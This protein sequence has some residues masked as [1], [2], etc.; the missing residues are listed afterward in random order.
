MGFRKQKTSRPALGA[1]VT[2]CMI[3]LLKNQADRSGYPAPASC[4]QRYSIRKGLC[5][6][7]RW[8][9]FAP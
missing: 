5:C 2:I 9:F 7:M 3:S 6:Q 8:N 1:Y 4:R